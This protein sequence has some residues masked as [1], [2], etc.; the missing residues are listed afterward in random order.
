MICVSSNS[1]CHVRHISCHSSDSKPK[2][3][4]KSIAYF[5]IFQVESCSQSSGSVL[6]N[7]P[8]KHPVIWVLSR[9]SCC[10]VRHILKILDTASPVWSKSK[11]KLIP[12]SKLQHI[13]LKSSKV[14]ACQFIRKKIGGPWFS[15]F[16]LKAASVPSTLPRSVNAYSSFKSELTCRFCRSG[17]GRRRSMVGTDP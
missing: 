5:L 13:D 15:F 17:L 4:L 8:C 6:Q 16:F 9:V 11:I 3:I 1:C 10:H 12:K 14:E 7:V 2:L